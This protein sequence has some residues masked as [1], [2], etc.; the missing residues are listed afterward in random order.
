MLCVSLASLSLLAVS[1]IVATHDA[2]ADQR[3]ERIDEI[4]VP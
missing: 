3:V 2:P 1:L 4:E